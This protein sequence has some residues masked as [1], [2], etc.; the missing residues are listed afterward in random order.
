MTKYITITGIILSGG[1]SS[2]MGQD[3][4]FIRIKGERVIDR[5]VQLMKN[6]F[7]KVIIISNDKEKYE[8]LGIPVYSD[9]FKDVGPIAGVHSGLLH[10]QTEQNFI[11]SCDLPFMNCEMIKSIID[12]KS[13]SLIILPKANG[14]I[15]SLCGLYSK[16]LTKKIEEIINSDL[17]NELEV[18]AHKKRNLKLKSLINSVQTEIIENIDE[19]KGYHP[20][21]F[22]NMNSQEDYQQVIKLL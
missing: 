2:R 8:Y 5:V 16:S 12:F 4:S 6:L 9:I 17:S 14:Y 7:E 1:K 10:S 11:I 3:K 19:F 20:N 18:Y 15:Q 22:F 13:N 21:V